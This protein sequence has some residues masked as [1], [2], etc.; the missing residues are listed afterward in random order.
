MGKAPGRP[1]KKERNEQVLE[2]RK[3][4]Y[5]FRKIAEI[6]NIDVK[7]IYDIYTRETKKR[8]KTGVR[9]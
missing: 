1:S 4:G 6:F 7:T 5:T 9:I 2:M 3:K 8:R